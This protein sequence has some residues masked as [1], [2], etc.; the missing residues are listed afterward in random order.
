MAT[1]HNEANLG[2][3]A[4]T[5]LMSGDPLRVKAIAEKYLDNPKLVNKIRNIYAYTGTYKGKKVTIMAHGMGIPSM[6]IYAYELFKFYEVDKII[7]LGSCGAYSEDLNLLDI[8]LVDKSYTESNF[9]YELNNE[10]VNETESS[11]DVNDKLKEAAKK[12][13]INLVEGNVMST[14]CFDWY[15]KDI[16]V[17]L[18]RLPNDVIAAEME[19][20]AL[21]YLAEKFNKKAAC[22]LTVVDSHYK[23]EE[24]SAE[25]RES[26]LDNMAL[27]ALES[28]I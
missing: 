25:D 18:D 7:R 2:D 23:K 6:G 22:L 20:F 27:V 3:I 8:L 15:V 11:K 26:K 19:S 17:L 13:G 9:S 12:L 16:K 24:L 10:K 21:F 1:A 14:D 28:I 5:V 4:K